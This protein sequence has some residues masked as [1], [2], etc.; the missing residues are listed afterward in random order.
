MR[1][2]TWKEQQAGYEIIVTPRAQER[3]GERRKRCTGQDRREERGGRGAQERR[4]EEGMHRTGQ[5][6]R[7]EE[8]KLAYPIPNKLLEKRLA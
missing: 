7:E 3:T 2:C 6:R 8:E 4:E 1:Y 5:E